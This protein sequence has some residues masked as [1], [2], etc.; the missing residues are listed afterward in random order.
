MSADDLIRPSFAARTRARTRRDDSA[1]ALVFFALSIVVLM[2]IAALVVDVGYWFLHAQ[3]IQRAADAA[4]LAGVVWMP[5]SPS[6]ATTTAM[7]A[8]A[9]NGFSAGVT[10]NT[11]VT[12]SAGV[13]EPHVLKVSITDTDVPTFFAKVFGLESITETR[14]ATAEYQPSVPLGSAENSFGTGG[15]SLDAA[16]DTSNVWAAVNGYCTS[17]ENGDEFL[18]AFDATY[19]G[20]GYSCSSTHTA[21]TPSATA[22]SEYNGDNPTSAGYSY[23][24]VTPSAETLGFTTAPITIDAY[25]PGF[26]PTQCAGQ[27]ASSTFNPAGGQ[28][29]DSNLGGAA[30]S[31]TTDYSLTYSPVPLDPS[32]DSPMP[33]AADT[34]SQA[35]NPYVAASGDPTTCGQWVNLFTIPAGSPNGDYRLQVTTPE[36]PGQ[37]SDGTNA[38]ALRVNEGPTGSAWSRCSNITTSAFYNASLPCPVIQ[39]ENALGVFATQL[40]STSA[41]PAGAPAGAKCGAFYLAQIDQSY[42]G[43]ELHVNLFDPGEGSKDIELLDPDGNP[44]SFFWNVTDDCPLSAP[45]QGSSDCTGP[46]GIPFTDNAA[47]TGGGTELPVDGTVTP[48]TGIV[49]NSEFND[50]HVQLSFAIPSTYTGADNGGWWKIEYISNG[51]IQDRTTWQVALGGSPIHL[52]PPSP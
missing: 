48:P 32:F 24:I 29:V 44:V 7:Q 51:S 8:A 23:D 4:A 41:C 20:S 9:G 43:H 2:G 37:L 40:G 17:K 49:S 5:G 28:T 39:G 1:F 14:T 6:N 34:N 25:D 27:P 33:A 11:N 30:A 47:D 3:K 42:A 46:Q 45:N 22:N 38:Y 15:L 16:G 19:T 31:M 36:S 52:L 10:V 12:N 18:S 26:Q 35:A 50:R 21:K 13:F